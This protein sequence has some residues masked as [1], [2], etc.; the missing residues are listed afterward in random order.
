MS[1][2]VFFF[3]SNLFHR[4]LI[5]NLHIAPQILFD[6]F[7]VHSMGLTVEGFS[8]LV[9]HCSPVIPDPPS[10]LHMNLVPP[11]GALHTAFLLPSFS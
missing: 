6:K 1:A 11:A 2:R 5:L 9:I 4:F 8:R 3:Q 10:L 7:K